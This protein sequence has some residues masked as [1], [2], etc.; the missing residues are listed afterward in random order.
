MF[1]IDKYSFFWYNEVRHFSHELVNANHLILDKGRFRP[2]N[3]TTPKQ[4][5]QGVFVTKV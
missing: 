4:K 3:Y 1:A 2:K 5:S